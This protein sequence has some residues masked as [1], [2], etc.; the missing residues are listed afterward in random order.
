MSK[1]KIYGTAYGGKWDKLHDCNR[2][3]YN[4]VGISPT[5]TCCGGGNTEVKICEK[6]IPKVKIRKLTPKECFR[7]MDFDDEDY[8]KA[9]AVNSNSQLYKQAGNSIVVSVLEHIFGEML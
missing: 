2:R 3:I 5:L 6:Q 9:K 7:L 4:T 1:I 8:E